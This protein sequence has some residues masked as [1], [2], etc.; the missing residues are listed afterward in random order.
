MNR[1]PHATT[2][3]CVRRDDRVALGGDGQ[4]TLGDTVVKS[5]ANKVRRLG[6]GEVLAG[7]AGGV[8]DAFTLFELFEAE[9]EKHRGQ[10]SRAAVEMA[11]AWRTEQR[12]RRLDAL[13][14]VADRKTSLLVSGNGEVI[15]PEHGLIAIGSGGAYALA[16]AR[17]LL[18]ETQYDAR[19]VVEKALEIASEICIYTNSNR[20]IEELAGNE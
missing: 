5:S 2:I 9:L 10:L 3:V 8:A 4:V 19:T 12:L 16:A 18:A 7:F 20:V 11:K 15:E 6:G 17:V 1:E 14:A 13:L